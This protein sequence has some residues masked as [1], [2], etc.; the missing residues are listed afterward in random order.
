MLRKGLAVLAACGFLLVMMNSFANGQG[1][2]RSPRKAGDFLSLSSNFLN[3]NG[4][5][6][7]NAVPENEGTFLGMQI[8][9][10]FDV[11]PWPGCVGG[12]EP[13]TSCTNN[14][15][16]EGSGVCTDDKRF[17]LSMHAAVVRSDT[18]VNMVSG[19]DHTYLTGATVSMVDAPSSANHLV[20]KTYADKYKPQ[21]FCWI[22]ENPGTNVSIAPYIDSA[23][24][25]TITKLACVARG[26]GSINVSIEECTNDGVTC[27][28]TGRFD[29][30]L[31]TCDDNGITTLT[32]FG[33]DSTGISDAWFEITLSGLS[34]TVTGLSVCMWVE[35]E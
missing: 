2:K 32:S 34:G 11:D 28:G 21:P 33:G 25:M 22:Y 23:V 8:G 17:H 24:S 27:A 18:D 20:N 29:E 7:D 1:L 4:I 30:N 12:T 14:T 19:T 13:G 10:N 3:W 5:L 9:S 31:S 6:V 26:T 16:C 35:Y 15:D